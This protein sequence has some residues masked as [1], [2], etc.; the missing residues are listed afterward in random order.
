MTITTT[1]PDLAAATRPLELDPALW[2][3]L[4][5]LN[6]SGAWDVFA[7]T[8]AGA[9]G[10]TGQH[11]A[12]LHR[13]DW[14]S[15]C[16]AWTGDPADQ[17]AVED[18]GTVLL[19]L[20]DAGLPVAA[21]VHRCNRVLL[22]LAGRFGRRARI[23]TILRLQPL[24]EANRDDLLTCEDWGLIRIDRRDGRPFGRDLAVLTDAGRALAVAPHR[25]IY[26]LPR[27][28]HRQRRWAA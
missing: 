23:G 10:A 6:A 1:H 22:Y 7:L 18:L 20:T 15:G 4:L 16:D 24:I 17:D 12:A 2:A 11:F 28:V 21:R 5:Q 19:R 14:V 26:R 13:K 3:S 9:T 25:N 8:L 27:Q